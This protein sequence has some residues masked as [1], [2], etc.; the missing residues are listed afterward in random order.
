[1]KQWKILVSFLCIGLLVV[2]LGFVA[3]EQAAAKA[4]LTIKVAGISPK[5]YRSTEGLYRIEKKVEEGTDGRIQMEIFPMN[6]LGDY[7]QVFEEI[8]RGTIEMGLIFIPSQYDV[9]LELGSLPFLAKD[10]DGMRKQLS[11]GSYVYGVLEETL[12]KLGVKLLRIQGEGFIGVGSKKAPNAPADPTVDK[13]MLIRIAPLAVYKET[14]EDMGY[15]TTNIPYADTYSAIQ[16]GVCDGWIGGSA[17]I[18]YEVFRDVIKHYI[19]Y[20]CLFDQTGYLVNQKLWNSL[21]PEDQ[22]L[23]TDA[24]N[25]EADKSFEDCKKEN[26]VYMEKMKERGIEIVNLTEEERSALAE[27]IRNTTWPKFEDKFGKDMMDKVRESV[28]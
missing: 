2:T 16:T 28:Q 3:T 15:R 10:A 27:Y 18:N 24:V 26:E 22:K 5:E 21:S 1:M 17:R 23:I 4:D 11:P 7:T 19:P 13:D 14:A 12:D 20:N 8:R 9:K 6:Q 25:A